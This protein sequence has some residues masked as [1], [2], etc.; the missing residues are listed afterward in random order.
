MNTPELMQDFDMILTSLTMLW[1]FTMKHIKV[2]P[3]MFEKMPAIL[4]VF[5]GGTV[6][7]LFL[8]ATGFE[9]TA[10]SAVFSFLTASGL[11]ELFK[12]VL[13]SI[14]GFFGR[15]FSSIFGRDQKSRDKRIMHSLRTIDEERFRYIVTESGK[16]SLLKQQKTV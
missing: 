5:A 9:L 2:S 13:P 6:I 4:R 3:G 11:Y 12:G 8:R 16:G 7:A 10:L 14:P 1:G 15:L